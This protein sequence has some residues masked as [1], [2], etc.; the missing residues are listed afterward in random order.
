M[1]YDQWFYFV[2]I[3]S[4]HYKALRISI[5]DFINRTSRET[6]N[7]K[8]KRATPSDW[9]NYITASLVIKIM[10]DKIPE[11]FHSKLSETI[12]STRW[13][14]QLGKLYNNARGKIGKQSIQNW[15]QHMDR[16][17]ENYQHSD[18]NNDW[19]R[20]TLKKTLF[21]YAKWLRITK[22]LIEQILFVHIVNF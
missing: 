10:R 18:W 4:A 9:S 3:N 13:K 15:L 14:H 22:I 2:M 11:H 16:L 17:M 7:I 19:I 1:Y 5:N 6:L 20:T 12:Y 21:Q 8:L